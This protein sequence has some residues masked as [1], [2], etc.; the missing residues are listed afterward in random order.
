MIDHTFD[1]PPSEAHIVLGTVQVQSCSACGTT[2]VQA[3]HHV[4]YVRD[5]GLCVL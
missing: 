2:D 3:P 1:D 5:H 4:Q